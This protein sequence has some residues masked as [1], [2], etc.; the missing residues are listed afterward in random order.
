[1]SGDWIK[2]RADLL[3]HPK[4]VRMMSALR[5]DKFRTVGGLLSAWCLFDAHSIDGRLPGYTLDALDAM[6]AW[7]GFAAAMVAVEWLIVEEVD[8][9]ESLVLPRFDAHN[10]QSAKR[11]AQEADRKR[12]DRK[13]SASDA[14]KKRTREEK[15][16]EEKDQQQQ[17]EQK[18]GA[19]PETQSGPVP[20]PAAAVAAQVDDKPPSV[21][22]I[23]VKFFAENG[24]PGPPGRTLVGNLRKVAQGQCGGNEAAGDLLLL[25]LIAELERNPKAEPDAWIR[26]A[27]ME[28]GKPRAPPTHGRPASISTPIHTDPAAF[29]NTQIQ[30]PPSLMALLE[31]PNTHGQEAA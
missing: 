21:I 2:M 24:R 12:S 27:L 10:G 1:M 11:R 25:E 8:G 4:V 5:A 22:D 30:G 28:R 7:P 15:R 9:V 6:A 26:R 23:A 17:Q 14:D 20:P 19:E 31:Q 13:T 29:G 16:R 18:R 3:T